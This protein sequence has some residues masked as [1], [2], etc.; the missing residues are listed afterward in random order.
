MQVRWTPRLYE[1]ESRAYDALVAQSP[2]GHACQTRPWSAVA[3]AAGLVSTAFVTVHGPTSLVG[4]ALVSRPHVAGVGLPWARIER[5]P[6]V[7]EP[8]LLGPCLRAIEREA[9]SR[10]IVR[11]HVMP[12]WSDVEAQQAERELVGHGYRDVQQPGGAHARTL[13][14]DL[15]PDGSPFLAG[16]AMAQ[17]RWRAGQAAR[18][19]ATARQGAAGDWPEL[20]SMHAALMGSQGR[21]AHPRAWWTA[22]EAFA[23]GD[24]RGSLFVCEHGGRVVSACVA[25]RHGARATYAWAAS[26]PDDLPFTKAVPALVAAV[27]WARAAGCTAFDL[28]G[29]PLEGDRDPKR[30]AIA[31]FKHD[32]SRR[33][34]RLVREHARWLVP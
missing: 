17:V 18:C 3:G 29:I 21:R 11:L 2:S 7:A 1:E 5:G 22:L 28:G 23:N 12:Y 16:H 20:R 6:V 4:A 26:V 25:L 9:R 34:V 33:P 30:T 32:F 13:R 19:G 10:G 27:R 31:V 24:A 15:A 8:S 14:I